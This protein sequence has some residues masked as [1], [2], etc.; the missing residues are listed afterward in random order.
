MATPRRQAY[1]GAFWKGGTVD[2]PLSIVMNSRGDLYWEGGDTLTQNS[3]KPSL[4]K[5]EASL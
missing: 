3:D 1:R 4:N 5:R 2:P